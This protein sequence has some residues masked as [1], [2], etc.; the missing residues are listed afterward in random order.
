M[1]LLIREI[2]DGGEATEKVRFWGSFECLRLAL[3]SEAV[4][5][6]SFTAAWFIICDVMHVVAGWETVTSIEYTGSSSF[7]IDFN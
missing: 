2:Q 5:L 3:R 7:I 6:L 4:P 1:D